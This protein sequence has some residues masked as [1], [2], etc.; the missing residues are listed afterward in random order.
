MFILFYYR[1]YPLQKVQGL[2]FGMDKTQAH[3][4]LHQLTPLV[5]KALD[6][7]LQP[8]AR[9]TASIEEV[10]AAYPEPSFI[11]DGTERPVER[12]KDKLKN[13]YN[14]KKKKHTGNPASGGRHRL[15]LLPRVP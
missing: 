3:D 8:P 10:L 9:D 4:W 1:F 11:I 13:H 15:A 5:S 12:P 6:Y 2:F 7:E 14:G